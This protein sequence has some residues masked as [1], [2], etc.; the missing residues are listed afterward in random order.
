M[1]LNRWDLRWS[2]FKANIASMVVR[3]VFLLILRK[4]NRK[5][6]QKNNQKNNSQKNTQIN[7][8]T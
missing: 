7:K 5:T 2:A 3:K 1:H 4:N 6:H 8:T